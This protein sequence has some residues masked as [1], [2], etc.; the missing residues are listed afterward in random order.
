MRT[1]TRRA[2]RSLGQGVSRNSTWP[3]APAIVTAWDPI[4]VLPTH[5]NQHQATPAIKEGT[6]GPWNPRPPGPPAVPSSSSAPKSRSTRFSAALLPAGDPPGESSEPAMIGHVDGGTMRVR[7]SSPSR[8]RRPPPRRGACTATA[9]P[10]S[11]RHR[12]HA[13]LGSARRRLVGR[14]AGSLT[15]R[16]EADG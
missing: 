5:P 13:R 10:P 15:A 1:R 4:T 8:V 2:P 3:W 16:G 7:A 12:L 6:Q 14:G 9:S 11:V